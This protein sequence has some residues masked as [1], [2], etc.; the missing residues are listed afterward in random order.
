M[1]KTVKIGNEYYNEGVRVPT[2][3]AKFSNGLG[4]M[5]K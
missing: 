2:P 5:L 1:A 4:G 3:K